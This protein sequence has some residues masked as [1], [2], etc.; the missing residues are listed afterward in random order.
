V[1]CYGNE[2]VV[3][4]FVG[5]EFVFYSAVLYT[6]FSLGHWYGIVRRDASEQGC[7]LNY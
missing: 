3:V 7:G 4:A 1:V 2:S 5:R 6:R